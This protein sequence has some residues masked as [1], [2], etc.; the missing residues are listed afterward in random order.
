ME[1]YNASIAS[2]PKVEMIHVSRDQADDAAQDWAAAE[3]FPWLTVLPGDVERSDL[4]Q[5]RT[6]NAVPF[7]TMVDKDG[8]EVAN[9]SGAIFAKVAELGDSSE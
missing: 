3:G 8:N 4:L 9:G 7:Y 1:K 5:F 2:N 6:R